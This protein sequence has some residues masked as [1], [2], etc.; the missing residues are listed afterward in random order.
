MK[1]YKTTREIDFVHMQQHVEANAHG[2]LQGH[3]AQ[4]SDAEATARGTGVGA[5]EAETD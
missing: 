2:A 4:G 5:A 1:C 3:A